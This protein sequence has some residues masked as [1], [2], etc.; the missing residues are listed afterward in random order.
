MAIKLHKEDTTMR[1]ELIFAAD[2]KAIN[3][4]NAMVNLFM[5][6]NH[7]GLRPKL[8]PRD[9]ASAG[10]DIDRIKKNFFT[11]DEIGEVTGFK[12]N[13]EAVEWWIRSNLVN[14]VN[15]G[16]HDDER[17]SSLRPIHLESYKVR[18][19]H[20]AR[21][22]FTADQI[23]F[24]LGT[25]PQT[26]DD[27]KKFL[28]EGWDKN[29]GK[30]INSAQLDIDSLGILNLVK[31]IKP[32][33]LES[34]SSINR[35]KPLLAGQAELYC[36]D[37]RRLLVYH[38][39]KLIPRSVLIDYL[40]TITSF[41][42]SI[43]L[44][45]LVHYLP[46]M[47]LNGSTDIQDEWNI[48]VDVTDNFDSKVASLSI[49]DAE[50]LYN[51]IYDYVKATFQING[52]LC[53]LGLDKSDSEN[54]HKALSIIAHKPDDFETY[55]KHKWHDITINLEE[56][57]RD[58]IN[59]INEFDDSFFEKYV[60][61]IIKVRGPYQ[62]RY[63]TQLIDNLSQKNSDRALMA[64]GRSKRHPRR[65]I[66]GTRLLETLVQILVL[67]V[68]DGSFITKTLSIEELMDGL[69]SRYGIV[70][71]GLSEPRFKNANIEIHLAFKENV[72]A[73]KNKLRQIG[74]YNDLSDAYILQ[75]V[76]PRYE[77][78]DKK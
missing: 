48:V 54:L 26:R 59:D 46:Q 51:K 50:N 1:N 10:F 61:F 73:F 55:F 15:R 45:K 22:Y 67:D 58:I 69:R 7:N 53:Y 6:L 62:Y 52:T 32:G 19:P 66:M 57:D 28:S 30:I 78:A 16:R 34:Q 12:D 17:I 56:E 24:M 36:E 64:Q 25:N 49:K 40:K 13:P 47:V 5:L 63:H 41:H 44:Q 43:Y 31:N 11:Q 4:D 70:I 75:R 3:I 27:L 71:N 23:Y 74:F 33:F 72:E 39:E 35:I 60:E 38:T 37:V 65:F 21:D 29:T 77:I 9:D 42:L 8:R 2:A 20:H 14:M 68:S 18:N 76:N